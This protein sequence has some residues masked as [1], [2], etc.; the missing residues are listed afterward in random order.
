[1]RSVG[2]RCNISIRSLPTR[3]A[4]GQRVQQLFFE[5]PLPSGRS[6]FVGESF[7]RDWTMDRIAKALNVSQR[8][9]SED[10][11][12]LE[13]PSKS[14]PAKTA[15]NPKGAGRHKGTAA[16]AKRSGP[17]PQRRK[18]APTPLRWRQ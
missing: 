14:K 10:L 18:T 4:L 11:R 9:I 16:K 6:N 7:S 12:N 5:Q 3:G 15:S 1:V 2:G 13:V 8:T 17:Q